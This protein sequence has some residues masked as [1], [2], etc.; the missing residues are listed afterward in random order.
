[1]IV[2]HIN[3]Y[4]KSPI[5]LLTFLLIKNSFNNTVLPFLSVFKIIMGD[6]PTL[7]RPIHFKYLYMHDTI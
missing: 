2:Q 1:M 5:T 3:L 4:T 7:R 6:V